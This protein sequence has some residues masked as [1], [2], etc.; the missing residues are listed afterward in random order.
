MVTIRQDPGHSIRTTMRPSPADGGRGA[1]GLVGRGL[2]EETLLMDTV[3]TGQKRQR[4]TCAALYLCSTHRT[5]VQ[6]T[7]S[8][9]WKGVRGQITLLLQPLVTRETY[10]QHQLVG[11]VQRAS[12]IRQGRQSPLPQRQ[13]TGAACRVVRAKSPKLVE[14]VAGFWP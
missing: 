14:Q 13:L 4:C 9:Q 1:S 11:Q 8:P 2:Q 7:D 6:V 5:T 12:S 10:K 3:H